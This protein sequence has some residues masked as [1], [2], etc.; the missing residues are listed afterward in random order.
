MTI[1]NVGDALPTP[2]TLRPTPGTVPGEWRHC[3]RPT[4]AMPAAPVIP[5]RLAAPALPG[6]RDSSRA[7]YRLSV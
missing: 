3:L 5:P 6:Y 4:Q 1:C 2:D 7:R